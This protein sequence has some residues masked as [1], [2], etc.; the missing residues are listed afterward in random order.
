[1]SKN[2][3][4]FLDRQTNTT[5]V[6]LTENTNHR[7]QKMSSYYVILPPRPQYFRPL[8]EYLITWNR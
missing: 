7:K 4:E 1:M 6:A 2:A 8:G 3:R 5:E